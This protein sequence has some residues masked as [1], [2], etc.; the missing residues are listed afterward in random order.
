MSQLPRVRAL[1]FVVLLL[2]T[3]GFVLAGQ[4][5]APQ[6]AV[7][8][9]ELAAKLPVDPD[10]TTGTFPN[11][12]KYYVRKNALPDKRAEL[13]LVVNAGSL[14]EEDDQQGLAHFVEHM[15]FN[16][17][18]NFPKSDIV[19]FMESIGMRFGPSVNAFTSFD[20]TVYMLQVP[21]DKPEVL[22]RSL[23]ILE[24]WAR[25]VSFDPAEVDKERGVIMEEWRLRRGAGARMQDQQL[26]ILLKGSRYAERVPIGKPEVIQNFTHDRL[27]QFYTDWYRPDLMAVIAVGDFDKAAVEGLIKKHFAAI[28]AASKPK[29]RP[30]FD[31]PKQPGTMYSVTTDPETPMANVS[32]YS[33][34]AFRDPTTAGAYRTQIVE[35]LFGA[36]L[37]ARF[38]E[39]A[40]K[41][42]SPILGA[43]ASR[44]LFVKSAEASTLSAAAKEDAIDLALE[45]LFR[46]TERV[47]QFGFT[48]AELDREKASYLR[49]YEQVLTEIDKRPS[50][51]L[52]DEYVRNFTQTEP[53]PG[54]LNEVNWCAGSCRASRSGK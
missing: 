36:M 9:A 10:V 26:P 31:I 40:R 35:R 52:A 53:F 7:S 41:P 6:Q 11:G 17:T 45:L 47:A 33:K 19:T 39:L 23:L 50:G 18:K 28:P 27:K 38:Q 5:A 1:L 22:D 30:A 43:G 2:S 48:P 13:R 12:L 14:L 3:T 54:L 46:E 21:T 16:G 32:V 49:S 37:S 44:G 34:M 4:A 51:Q 42:D 29:P 24:D 15:A 25:A 20:E 8:A